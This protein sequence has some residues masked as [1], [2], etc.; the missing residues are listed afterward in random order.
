MTSNTAELM[1]G[2]FA[3]GFFMF[4]MIVFYVINALTYY[5]IAEKAGL[6]NAWI[7]FIPFLQFII[8]FHVIDK[9]AWWLL[10]YI[11]PFVN[12]IASI[13]FM[14]QFMDSFEIPGVIIILSFFVPFLMQGIF[15]YMAFSGNCA[16]KRTNRFQVKY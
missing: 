10:I 7:A 13:I 2:L 4:F 15:L 12:V 16:Y 8:M 14:Y 9:S 6:D 1:G 5:K 11:V 3:S